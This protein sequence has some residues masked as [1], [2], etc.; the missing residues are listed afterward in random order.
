M[1]AHYCSLQ[2]DNGHDLQWLSEMRQVS[3]L[4]INMVLPKRGDLSS[5]ALQTAFEVI[6]HNVK[7]LGGKKSFGLSIRNNIITLCMRYRGISWPLFIDI[8]GNYNFSLM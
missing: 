1:T 7:T 4:F 2:I 5:W 3:V 8:A 6:Y